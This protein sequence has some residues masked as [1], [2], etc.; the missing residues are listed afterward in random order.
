MIKI[1]SAV[2]AVLALTL[3]FA[4]AASAQPSLDGYSDV[5]GNV[6]DKVDNEPTSDDEPTNEVA[7]TQEGGG[8]DGGGSPS[9]VTRASSGESLPFTGLDVA[10][11]VGAGGLFVALGFG[12]RR[13]TRHSA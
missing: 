7:A 12:M 5:G 2:M 13:L 3:V 9:G 6:Q 4:S 11:L 10:L 8:G 1:S